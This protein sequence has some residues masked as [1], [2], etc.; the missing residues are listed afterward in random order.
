MF[1]LGCVIPPALRW[2][3]RLARRSLLSYFAEDR[4]GQVLNMK[5]C[6]SINPVQESI[7]QGSETFSEPLGGMQCAFMALSALFHNEGVPVHSW[8]KSVI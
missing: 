1:S 3:D 6:Y 5:Y 8:T 2:S 4:K 7:H